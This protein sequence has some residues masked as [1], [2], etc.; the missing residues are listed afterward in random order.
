[1]RPIGLFVFLAASALAQ[2][3]APPAFE[4]ASVKMNPGFSQA[5]RA[6]W[7]NTIDHSPTSLTMR[8]VDLAMAVAWAYHVQRAEVFGPGWIDSTR[9]D[10]LAKTSRPSKESEMRRMLKALL[11][12]RFQLEAHCETR[13]LEVMALVNSRAGHRM[14]ASETDGRLQDRED[15]VRGTVITGASLA[16]LANEMSREVN[17]PIVDRTGLSGRF[18]F[19]FNTQKYLLALRSRVI[20]DGHPPSESDVRVMLLEDVVAGELGLRLEPRRAPVEVVVIDRAHKSPAE[21]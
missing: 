20:S 18:D 15:P 4:V 9:Y 13:Q 2:D 10:I 8:N 11:V 19:T 21:N 14:T 5:D 7:H 3:A 16:E 1:M 12:E 17:L 6:T